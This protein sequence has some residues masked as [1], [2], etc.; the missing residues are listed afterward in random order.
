MCQANCLSGKLCDF[1]VHLKTM[2]LC[3]SLWWLKTLQIFTW[4]FHKVW[5]FLSKRVRMRK[6]SGNPLVSAN[7]F[8]SSLR[9]L[10]RLKQNKWEMKEF[11]WEGD[12]IRCSY[13]NPWV[14]IKLPVKVDVEKVFVV[15]EGLPGFN[16]T[17][18]HLVSVF[19]DDS[20]HQPHLRPDDP[21]LQHQSIVSNDHTIGYNNGKAAESP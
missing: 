5:N 19:P 7:K 20:V 21:A 9:S 11:R 18:V 13:N 17:N 10:C 8:S 6:D 1:K 15:D 16:G 14:R 2:M 3:R 4:G 12:V